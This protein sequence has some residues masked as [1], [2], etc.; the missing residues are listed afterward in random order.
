MG[1]SRIGIGQP[2][3]SGSFRFDLR[4]HGEARG[5][6]GGVRTF[7]SRQT[8]IEVEKERVDFRAAALE[9]DPAQPVFLQDTHSECL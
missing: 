9:F 2:D 7:K 1:R 5:N 6:R 8:R 4:Q 3:L